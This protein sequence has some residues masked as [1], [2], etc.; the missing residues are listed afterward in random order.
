MFLTGLGVMLISLLLSAVL[1]T[2][3]D[4]DSIRDQNQDI[5]RNIVVAYIILILINIFICGFSVAC[6]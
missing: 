1:I 3:Y 4:L 6:A 2:I 5:S